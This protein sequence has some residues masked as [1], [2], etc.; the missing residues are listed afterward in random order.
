MAAKKKKLAAKEPDKVAI[1]L[2]VNGT[3]LNASA[4]TLDAAILKLPKFQPKTVG[5]LTVIQQGITSRPI[6]LKIHALK[7]LFASGLTGVI[8]RT[9]LTKRYEFFA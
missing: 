4:D 7:R 3:V 9:V 2:K 5:S 1:A 8:N 6:P